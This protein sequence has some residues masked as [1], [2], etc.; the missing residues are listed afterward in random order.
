MA[1]NI[2]WNDSNLKICMYLYGKITLLR[3]G[4]TIYPV[5]D[6]IALAIYLFANVSQDQGLYSL[7]RSL[8]PAWL[9]WVI[10][11]NTGPV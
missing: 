4:Y 9:F 11:L 6:T 10:L 5:G 8:I 2:A 3:L 1:F 7:K